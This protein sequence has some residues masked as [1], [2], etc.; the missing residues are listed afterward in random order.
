VFTAPPL[1][2]SHWLCIILHTRTKPMRECSIPRRATRS[3]RRPKQKHID[4]ARRRDPR[5]PKPV[6]YQAEVCFK[7][8]LPNNSNSTG[9]LLVGAHFD[10]LADFELRPIHIWIKRQEIGEQ[11]AVG[12]GDFCTGVAGLERVKDFSEGNRF[13]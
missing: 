8:W 13:A 1:P 5:Q 11:K 7:E 4:A 12:P 2:G 6:L 10:D 3:M 9:L